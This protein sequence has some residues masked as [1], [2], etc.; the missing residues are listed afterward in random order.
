MINYKRS[1]DELHSVAA[2]WWPKELSEED[3]SVNIIPRL[4]ET[5][6]KFLTILK[7]SDQTPFQVLDVLKVSCFPINLFIKHL[8]ILA[9]YGGEPLQRLGRSF[10]DIFK[11]NLEKYELNFNWNGGNYTYR[12]KELP[13]RGLGNK[14]LKIDGEGLKEEIFEIT[15]L[16]SD[17][18]MLLMHGASSTASEDAGLNSCE[19]GM[20]LGKEKELEKY[21][22][23]RYIF[24]SRITGGATANSLGQLV[25]KKVYEFLRENLCNSINVKSNSYVQLKKNDKDLEIP[26]DIVLQ[27]GEIEIGVEVSFQVTTNSTIERKA[28][29]AADRYSIMKENGNFMAYIIDGAGNFQRQSALSVICQHSD[30]TIAFTEKE[31]NVLLK[32][33]NEV[34]YA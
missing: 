34:V 14:K 2:L 24:V 22:E 3:A 4:V 11:K 1:I 19:I 5:Q 7:L 12:F 8:C 20:L 32:W 26:F 30:C 10:K 13:I 27:R 16:Y 31:L 18:I 15:D 17:V 28:G 29:Q 6:D 25:Q 9:D 21:V 23:Q 33:I